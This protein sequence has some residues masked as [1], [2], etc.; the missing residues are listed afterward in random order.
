MC[1]LRDKAN[2]ENKTIFLYLLRIKANK[3]KKKSPFIF[4]SQQITKTRNCVHFF[5]GTK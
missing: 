2:K 5:I 3:E 1:L 4:G